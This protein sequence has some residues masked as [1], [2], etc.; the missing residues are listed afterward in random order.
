MP[1][2][3]KPSAFTCRA[4]R[5][6]R[7]RA[8]PHGSVTRPSGKVKGDGPAADASEEMALD[9]SSKVNGP[10]VLDA[11]F[12]HVPCRNLAGLDE[13][14]Q[15]LRR[16]R[17]YFVVIVHRQLSDAWNLHPCSTPKAV[18]HSINSPISFWL[19]WLVRS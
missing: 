3:L 9:V 1:L 6:A 13:F 19:I 16:R 18:V 14:P 10:H 8:S 11:S 7:A 5:L 2:V 4:E 17:I 15:R 12:I